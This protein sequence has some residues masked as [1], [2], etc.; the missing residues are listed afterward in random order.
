[1]AGNLAAGTASG[2]A[3]VRVR[4][5]ASPAVMAGKK[6]AKMADTLSLSL[7]NVTSKGPA[8]KRRRMRGAPL[9]KYKIRELK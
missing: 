3:I 4:N 9:P 2:V 8:L 1:M 6:H 5:S 7:A